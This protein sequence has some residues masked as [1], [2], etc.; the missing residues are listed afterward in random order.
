MATQEPVRIGFIGAGAI[1]RDQHLPH[2]ARID[3]AEVVAVCNRSRES[4]EAV[5]KDF[6]IPDVMED[7]QALVARDDLDAVFIGT[8]PYMHLEMSKAVLEA[9]KHV[10]CQARMCMNLDEAK[11]MVAAA[12]AN[13]K[14][15]HMICPPPHRMPFEPY[16]KKVI[17]SGELGDI[18]LVELFHS[19]G[20][21]LNPNSVTWREQ[22]EYS[23]K[24][25]LA[26]G[27]CAETLNAWVGPYKTLMAQLSTP[28][29]TKKNAAG[30]SVDIKIPQV[31]T[32]TGTLE[33]GALVVEH[34]S[35]LIADASTPLNQLTVYGNKGTLRH[36][37]FSG[38]VLQAA[39]GEELKPVDVPAELQ[40]P[41]QV[42][43]DF[44]D[45]VHAARAGESWS[46]SPDFHEGLLYM[47]KV[48][49]VH[50]SATSG[51]A[52]DVA[53]Q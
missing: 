49:A 11:A 13:P 39:A 33:R 8:W 15:V 53:S 43:Q 20:G 3:S 40:R 23:G 47:R 29:P 30:E 1:C 22:V 17:D 26:M 14:Q 38:E 27:I 34:H 36:K 4:G 52:I 9:G 5:A 51:K 12:D 2:L 28:I 37:F 42:E 31:A 19:G 18:T 50:A 24:Q 7:W 25:I 41:W 6:G 45:A 48:E 32:I 46:V 10:F 44:V 35:G 21:N 16:I